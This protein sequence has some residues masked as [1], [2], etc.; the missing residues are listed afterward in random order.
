M[1]AR[2]V[3]SSAAVLSPAW[4]L[5]VL[6][7]PSVVR[8]VALSLALRTRD[9]LGARGATG[10]EQEKKATPVPAVRARLAAEDEGPKRGT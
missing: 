3:T 6:V 4:L 7:V 1:L 9:P 2:T 8:G 10:W 5:L